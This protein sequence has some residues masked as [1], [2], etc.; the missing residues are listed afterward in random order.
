[1]TPAAYPRQVAT[2]LLRFAI[3]IA[4]HDTHDWG[5]GMLSELNHVP[6]NWAALIWSIGGAGVLAKH[7]I[8]AVILPGNHR[9][10]VSSASELFSKEAPMRRATLAAIA[11]CTVASLLFFLAPVF[12]Q[13]FYISLAQWR[14][15]LHVRRSFGYREVDPALDALAEKAEQNHD[16]EALAFVAAREPNRSESVRLAEEAVHLDPSLTWLYAV[17]A[18]Q[19]SSFPELDRW[20]SAL[21]KLDP[22]NALPYLITAEK[23]DIDQV[24]RRE[25]PHQ[26]ED[27]P[28]AWKDAMAAA[29][30][31]E[32]LETYTAQLKA[33][34]RR[35][36]LSYHI[37][38]PFQTLVCDW[39]GLPSYSVGDSAGYARLLIESA[40][41]REA[42]GDRKGAAGTY[43]AV[44]R[45]G[46]ILGLEP[47]FFINR[48]MWEAYKHLETLSEM[49]GNKAEA[50]FYASL[51][52]Q[53][54]K[55]AENELAS[56][57]S[58]HRG[59]DVSHWNA[60]L[61]RLSGLL[62]LF[63]GAVLLL[64]VFGV[65]VRS[66]SLNL[67]SLSPSRATLVLGFG[68]ALGS[69]LS[70]VVLFASYWPYSELLQRFLRNG[71]EGG[72]SELSN[73]L[74][75]AQVPLGTVGC[76]GVS[77]AVFYFWFAVTIVCALALAIAVFRH[78]Q[79]RPRASAAT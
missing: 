21:E 59:S 44:A 46:Q 23:I 36:I 18:V 57:R 17:V 50:A 43:S 79:T 56:R 73:F 24:E 40:A 15:I 45:Y 60:F 42:H 37:T 71:D 13:A 52:G 32:K 64:C 22:Q 61:V 11:T 58:R 3:W 51:A 39:S 9:R 35:I 29:F 77:N 5:H 19:W 20:V 6:G 26:V 33:L 12:R 47:S 31:S 34:D 8:L 1:M 65:V 53:L 55:A 41:S 75:S 28:A 69:L 2:L 72:T 4:P 10:T 16:A 67:A 66:H 49:T 62:M 25:I 48:E 7:A 70:S 78:L 30:R 68:S 54:D 38:D 27:E 14:D 76:L 63:F 74:G